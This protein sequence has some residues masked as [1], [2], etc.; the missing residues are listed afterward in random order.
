MAGVD[1]N[2][3]ENPTPEQRAKKAIQDDMFARA[4]KLGQHGATDAVKAGQGVHYEQV[5][6]GLDVGPGQKTHDEY[7]AQVEAGLRGNRIEN[8]QG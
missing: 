4:N 2:I 3:G 6:R 1:S 8:W 7:I 5:S